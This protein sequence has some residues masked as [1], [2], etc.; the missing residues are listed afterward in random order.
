ML[1]PTL[2]IVGLLLATTSLC[3]AQTPVT[4]MENLA[5]PVIVSIK[6]GDETVTEAWKNGHLNA[7][8]ALA[9]LGSERLVDAGIALPSGDMKLASDLTFSLLEH[10]PDIL[11]DARHLQWRVLLLMANALSARKD[12]RAVPLYEEVLERQPL[13]LNQWTGPLD[14]A[15]YNLGVYYQRIGQL[16]KAIETTKRIYDYSTHPGMLSNYELL[17]ARLY[18][19]K[20]DNAEADKLYVLSETRGDPRSIGVTRMDQAGNLMG[21]RKMAEARALLLL[22]LGKLSLE[23]TR[24]HP[25]SVALFTAIAQSYAQEKDWKNAA[26]YANQAVELFHGAGKDS[27]DV[28]VKAYGPQAEELAA[29]IEKR[30]NAPFYW[31]QENAYFYIATDNPEFQESKRLTL[32]FRGAP[33]DLVSVECD[34]PAIQ[35]EPVASDAPGQDAL[36]RVFYLRVNPEKAAAI[37]ENFQS[38]LTARVAGSDF[39]ATLP[40]RGQILRP[41]TAPPEE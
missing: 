30:L 10:E 14:G 38:S 8:L 23:E 16:D 4:A 39:T 13:A 6:K 29:Q 5:K 26:L 1:K 32:R 24:Q 15:L 12:A 33:V 19:Q 21:Q 7:D 27:G 18:A 17:L 9:A 40:I 3:R 35:I 37:K 34:N 25:F 36:V 28:Y 22:P 2:W 31:E 20:G 11:A 41:E